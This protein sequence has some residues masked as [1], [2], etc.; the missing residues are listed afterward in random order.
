MV[1]LSIGKLH[2]PDGILLKRQGES[3]SLMDISWYPDDSGGAT[4]Y[5]DELLMIGYGEGQYSDI[6]A[7]SIHRGEK[8]GVFN[9]PE[10]EVPVS[11]LFLFFGSLDKRNYSKSICF[12]LTP[13]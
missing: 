9:L 6:K 4:A 5:W 3:S 11:H 7:T 10:L 2:L 1:Q 12:E 13:N 8:S